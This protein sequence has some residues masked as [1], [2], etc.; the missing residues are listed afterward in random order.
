MTK[1]VKIW[2]LPLRLFHWA[3]VLCVA[4]SWYT[5][6][7]LEDLQ[8]HFYSGYTLLGLL[9]FRLFWGFAGSHYSRFANFFLGSKT[10]HHLPLI[11]FWTWWFTTL[12]RPQPTWKFGRSRHA[13]RTL[14]PSGNRVIQ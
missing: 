6:E 1:S 7:I 8:L 4:F 10:A 9:L 12:P 2:D 5:I 3:L 11:V 13:R 14:F